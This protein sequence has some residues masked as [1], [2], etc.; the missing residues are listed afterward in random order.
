MARMLVLSGLLVLDPSVGCGLLQPDSCF[1]SFGD[2]VGLFNGGEAA[3]GLHHGSSSLLL[4]AGSFCTGSTV[5]KI[6][7]YFV[8]REEEIYI[9]SAKTEALM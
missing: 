3:A 4:Q 6:L 2:C 1:D 9:L 7:K 8:G 5:H